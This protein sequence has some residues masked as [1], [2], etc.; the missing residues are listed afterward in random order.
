MNQKALKLP[1]NSGRY[2]LTHIF[3]VS[4]F[5]VLISR[6]IWAFFQD[7]DVMGVG[8][9]A[10]FI[11]VYHCLIDFYIQVQYSLFQ[12]LGQWGRSKKRVLDER[13]L[14]KKIGEGASSLI[15]YSARPA[16]AFSIAP[17]DREPGT[18]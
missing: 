11:Q 5:E 1:N 15:S 13:D 4:R 7:L 12:A 14:V 8:R 17:T 6:F 9:S 10:C 3:D 18:G 2:H 16:P